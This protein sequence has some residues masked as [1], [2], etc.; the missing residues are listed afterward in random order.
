LPTTA[1]LGSLCLGFFF[2]VFTSFVA[3]LV[4]TLATPPDDHPVGRVGTNVS[5]SASEVIAVDVLA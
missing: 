5:R 3:V 4:L 2:S 1:P